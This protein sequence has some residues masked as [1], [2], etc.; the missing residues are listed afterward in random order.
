MR[1]KSMSIAMKCTNTT[2]IGWLL[3]LIIFWACTAFC[4][5]FNSLLSSDKIL[6]PSDTEL[7]GKYI[8][9]EPTEL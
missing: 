7:S 1:K 8:Q 6:D 5:V 4:K 9:E 2:E 3:K